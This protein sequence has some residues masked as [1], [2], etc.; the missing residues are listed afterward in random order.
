MTSP[1]LFT[2]APLPADA[3]ELGRIQE[4]WGVKGWL[5]ILP[6][7]AQTQALLAAKQ[8]HLQ[9][10]EARYRGG[11][12]AFSGSVQVAVIEVK[13]HADALVA[14]LEGVADRSAAEALK[15]ARIFLSRSAFPTTPEGE[16]YW[17]DLIGLEVVNRQGVHLGVVRDLLPTGPHAVLVLEYTDTS[18]AAGKSAE[19]LIPFVSAYV[20]RVDQPERCIT[21]DWQPDY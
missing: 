2:P 17:V 11:F 14:C 12:C 15:G 13:T 21:V 3:V 5:R 4:A 18:G 7:S 16:Y 19:R 9:P 8:W 6:H 10:P 20:D 1:G